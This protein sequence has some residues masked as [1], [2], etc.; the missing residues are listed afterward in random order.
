MRQFPKFIILLTS[1]LFSTEAVSLSCSGV[2]EEFIFSC[3][4]SECTPEFQ[5]SFK[6]S[7][8]ACARRPIILNINEDIGSYLQSEILQSS[9]PEDGIYKLTIYFRYWRYEPSEDIERLK[10]TILEEYGYKLLDQET[11]KKPTK[12]N[13]GSLLSSSLN[14]ISFEFIDSFENTTVQKIQA[15]KK[16]NQYAGLAKYFIYILLYWGSFLFCLS[17]LVYSMNRFYRHLYTASIIDK[18]SI[19]IQVALLV[20]SSISLVLMS[21][22]PWVGTLLL[23]VVVFVLITEIWAILRK[24]YEKA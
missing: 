2:T 24:K 22:N 20:I 6:K 3:K 8:G 12:L 1:L 9:S 17:S 19:V 18:K 4:D 16:S 11:G 14:S 5:V 10:S 7:G 23:P 21:W 15:E 13:P